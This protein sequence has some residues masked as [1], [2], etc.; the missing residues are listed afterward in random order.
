M[1]VSQFRVNRN[2]GRMEVQ[3]RTHLEVGAKEN[4]STRASY[5]RRLTLL[6]KQQVGEFVSSAVVAQHR[7]HEHKLFSHAALLDLVDSYPRELLQAFTMGADPLNWKEWH[8]VDTAGVSAKEAFAAIARGRL[9]FKMLQLHLVDN[10]Y[11]DVINEL[12]AELSEQC[13]DFRPI[14]KMGTLLISSPT[15]LVYYHA[16][17]QPTLLWHI[18]GSKRVWVYPAGDRELVDQDLM[19]DIF[20]SF[21]DEEI[22]YKREFDN[23]AKIFDLVPGDVVSLPQNAPH[24]V[25]NVAE[26][27]VSLS[28]LHETEHS[29]RRKL[30]YCANRLFRRTYHVPIRSTTENGFMPYAKRLAYRA[31]RRAGLVKTPP[32]RAYVTN[33][34][35]DASAL[36][37]ISSLTGPVLTEF[38]SK[39]ASL[40]RDRSVE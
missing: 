4:S 1:L 27:N 30:I 39:D 7:L 2:S 32:K 19:E 33:L 34:R 8:P 38:S 17:P 22:P 3:E 31:W 6:S 21:A 16:D 24:R 36:T 15:A 12:Y 13:P 23:K 26:V 28:T 18:R 5:E 29:D 25:T 10:R 11:R 20:A 40:P 9:W 14:R 35:I 37:G